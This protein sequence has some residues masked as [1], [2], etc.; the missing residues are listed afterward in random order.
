MQK[1]IHIVHIALWIVL[2]LSLAGNVCFICASLHNI[3]QTGG[4]SERLKSELVGTASSIT[5]A[6][7]FIES[8]DK[9]LDSVSTGLSTSSSTA[10]AI[11][12][13]TNSS[14]SSCGDIEQTITEL[15]AQLEVLERSCN[16]DNSNSSDSNL[17]ANSK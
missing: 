11:S 2:L 10:R 15:R 8:G 16:S 4:T 13:S 6:S 9:G 7:G 5:T 14:I 17:S 1:I 12:D 3:R